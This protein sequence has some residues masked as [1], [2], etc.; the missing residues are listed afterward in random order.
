MPSHPPQT[1]PQVSSNLRIDPFSRSATQVYPPQE[2]EKVQ[3]HHTGIILEVQENTIGSSP[4]LRLSND[5][6]RHDFLSQL[7]LS[8]L[9]GRHDHIADT[10][11]GQAVEARADTFD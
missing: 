9:D 10:T 11:S 7:R 2:A 5:N 1:P 6:R 3:T 8:L 4:G